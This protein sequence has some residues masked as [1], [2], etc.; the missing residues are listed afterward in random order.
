MKK[1]QIKMSAKKFLITTVAL[2][3]LLNFSVTKEASLMATD[4]SLEK[5]KEKNFLVVSTSPDFAPFEFIDDSH[6]DD[7][8]YVGADMELARYI[9]KEL[10]VE[11]KIEAMAFDQCYAAVASGKADIAI[12]GFSETEERKE[13]FNISAMYSDDEEQ[14]LICKKE[15]KSEINSKEVLKDKKI[16]VQ[17]SSLQQ[18]VVS[19]EL[20][21]AKMELITDVN[22]AVEMLARNK[23]DALAVGAS[24][25]DVILHN[26]PDL[27]VAD[28]KFDYV[29]KGYVALL[30]KGS[31]SLTKEI[32]TII[33][34]VQKDKLYDE[35]KKEAVDLAKEIGVE[36]N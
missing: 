27:A 28:F 35:W 30:K 32:D 13:N 5:V 24:N 23:V 29:E 15:L 14:V 3:N 8:Q 26:H 11:L 36:V 19:E 20:P 6:K 25:A 2:L 22:L 31:D 7:A 1:I 33:A 12:S 18:Q 10:G 17:N 16:A 4:D 9:A 21:E 34:K